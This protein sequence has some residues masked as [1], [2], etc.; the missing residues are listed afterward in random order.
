MTKSARATY[1]ERL[2]ERCRKLAAEGLSTTEIAKKL[3]VC[4]SSVHKYTADLKPPKKYW[5]GKKPRVY[6]HWLDPKDEANVQRFWVPSPEELA[7]LK[8]EVRRRREEIEAEA[9][10]LWLEN[11]QREDI[12]RWQKSKM[13]RDRK[14]L[15]R[16]V[17][18]RSGSGCGGE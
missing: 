12:K 13:K 6:N 17:L 3:G 11:Q 10:K 18:S 14:A 16:L 2:R 1:S 4:C 15:A 5:C 9:E 8:A 7:Q